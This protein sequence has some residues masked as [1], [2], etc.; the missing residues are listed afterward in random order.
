VPLSYCCTVE[1]LRQESRDFI[2]PICGRQSVG[3]VTQL[4]TRLE[5]HAEAYKKPVHDM[6]QKQRLVE[7]QS[8]FEQTNVNKAID[9]Q[10]KQAFV[11]T[12]GQHFGHSLFIISCI[13]W[14]DEMFKQLLLSVKTVR[15]SMVKLVR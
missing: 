13:M 4:S 14:T 9:Q 5:L 6:A 3:T 8:D 12:K 11:K 10:N 15:N 1:F 2:S 7:V